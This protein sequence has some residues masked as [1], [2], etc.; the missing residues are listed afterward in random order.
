LRF[1]LIVYKI[2]F[3]L[4]T[5][6]KVILIHV[7]FCFINELNRLI[8]MLNL[9]IIIILSFGK[10]KLFYYCAKLLYTLKIIYFITYFIILL[11]TLILVKEN[12]RSRYKKMNK[13]GLKV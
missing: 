12:Q 4:L 9:F 10:F 3:V 13:K 7:L 8:F 5:R 1:W 2:G 6:R 11:F